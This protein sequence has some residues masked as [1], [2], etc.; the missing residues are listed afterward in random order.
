[1]LQKRSKNINRDLVE[2]LMDEACIKYACIQENEENKIIALRKAI[3][4]GIES[5]RAVD[6][7]AKKYLD[8]LKARKISNG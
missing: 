1:M 7:D 4:D 6:F 3:N 5:G 2:K 8:V